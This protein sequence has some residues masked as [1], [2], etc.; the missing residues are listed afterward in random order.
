MAA[1]AL[2]LTTFSML[3]LWLFLLGQLDFLAPY[4]PLLLHS[5]SKAISLYFGVLAFNLYATFYFLA[6]VLFLKDTGS[7]LAHL[8]RQLRWDSGLSV[9]LS[10]RLSDHDGTRS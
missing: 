5:Y 1:H 7:K 2:V 6:R 3:A 4:R 9:E 8:N 10:R